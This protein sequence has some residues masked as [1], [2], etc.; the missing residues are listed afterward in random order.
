MVTSKD[1]LA[2]L[3][4]KPAMLWGNSEFPFT[5][6]IAFISGV[7]VGGGFPDLVPGDFHRF[8]AEHFGERWPSG[9]GWMSFIREHTS[10]EAEAFEMFFRLREEY[11]HTNAA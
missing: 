8:V 1:L 5:S 3:H 6:L 9:G 11:E 7:H 2:T 10:S 4:R